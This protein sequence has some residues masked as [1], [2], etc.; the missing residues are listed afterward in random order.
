M[1]EWVLG[2]SYPPWIAP[3]S[4]ELLKGEG[5]G[6]TR[7]IAMNIYGHKQRLQGVVKQKHIITYPLSQSSS[8]QLLEEMGKHCPRN[9]NRWTSQLQWSHS[10]CGKTAGPRFTT[11]V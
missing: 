9:L 6:H 1:D 10:M 4:M 8:R 3:N 11:L 2:Y 7:P 5:H